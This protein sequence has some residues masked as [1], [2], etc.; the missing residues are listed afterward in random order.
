M[1][2]KPPIHVGKSNCFTSG[3]TTRMF[4]YLRLY[5]IKAAK[6]YKDPPKRIELHQGP[7]REQS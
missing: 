5:Y 7:R 3:A 2:L 1:Y 6:L 4:L